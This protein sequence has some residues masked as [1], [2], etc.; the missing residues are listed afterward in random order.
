MESVKSC[1]TGQSSFETDL[2]VA[3]L[4]RRG[5]TL[6]PPLVAMAAEGS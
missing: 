4:Q 2:L 6:I 1:G 5:W 3:E